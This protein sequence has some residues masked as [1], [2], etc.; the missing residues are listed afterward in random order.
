MSDVLSAVK[1][2]FSSFYKFVSSVGLLLIAA[3]VA[4]PWFVLK[5]AVPDPPVKSAAAKVV[6][7]AI[8]LR[9][10]HY[11]FIMNAYP[12][13]SGSL[14]LLGLILTGYGLIAW[15]SRQKAH[16]SDEDEVYRQR[17]LGRTEKASEQDRVEK[18]DQEADE[19][20][21]TGDEQGGDS[22]S[23]GKRATGE[24][25]RSQDSGQLT[26]RSRYNLRRELIQQ[27]ESQVASLL[28]TAF[29]ETHLIETGVRVGDPGSPILDIVAR[30][31]SPD[32]W[33]SFAVEIRLFA[34]SR[35]AVLRLRD[36][37][38]AVAVAARDVPEGQVQ[39]QKVGRP[40]VAKSVSICLLVVQDE[41]QGEISS[42]QQNVESFRTQITR[43]VNV[44]NSV[45]LRKTGVIVV[46]QRDL[47]EATKEWLQESV[48][49]VMQRPEI[50]V[51]RL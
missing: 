22:L 2:D 8:D 17:R 3:A 47:L 18:L 21:A 1:L 34:R 23:E 36:T 39:V 30:S 49:E 25:D 12:W 51:M 28:A 44:I 11:A 40:P 37:M 43:T 16:D 6:D 31:T 14:L 45:L 24:S 10:E 27:A 29:T 7:A 42:W 33:T 4:L 5:S 41:D 46:S 13:I 9:A 48:L 38:L 20:Q 35:G 32:R 19:G 26:N 15:R 50:P